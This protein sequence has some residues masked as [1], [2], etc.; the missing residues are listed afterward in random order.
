MT[1]GDF[2]IGGG[3]SDMSLV[4]STTLPAPFIAYIYSGGEII[5]WSIYYIISPMVATS[6]AALSASSSTIAFALDINPLIIIVINSNDGSVNKSY[7][8]ITSYG[9]TSTHFI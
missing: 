5:A 4:A 2:I 7:K 3:T 6:V 9:R 8:D 1:N